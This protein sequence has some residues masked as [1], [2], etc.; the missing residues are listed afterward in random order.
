VLYHRGIIDQQVEILLTKEPQ[1]AYKRLQTRQ[2]FEQRARAGQYAVKTPTKLELTMTI[3]KDKT[4]EGQQETQH[5][6]E[7]IDQPFH[8]T[9]LSQCPIVH[10]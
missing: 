7:E 9:E 6:Q 10:N 2:Q 8:T 3:L 5:A 4:Y 1:L